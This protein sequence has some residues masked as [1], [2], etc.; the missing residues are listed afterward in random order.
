MKYFKPTA[1]FAQRICTVQLHNG[2]VEKRM[3]VIDYTEGYTDKTTEIHRT[4]VQFTEK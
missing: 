2:S 1:I 3:I 4:F